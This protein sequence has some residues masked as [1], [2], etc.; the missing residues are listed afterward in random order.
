MA[1][2]LYR[3]SRSPGRAVDHSEYLD[4]DFAGIGRHAGLGRAE[5]AL[6]GIWNS[7]AVAAGSGSCGKP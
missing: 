2:R 4:V 1:E 5:A 7:A 3:A 6:T